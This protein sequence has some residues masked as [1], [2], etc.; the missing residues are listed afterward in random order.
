MFVRA[1]E[2][3]MRVVRESA[4]ELFLFVCCLTRTGCWG[5]RGGGECALLIFWISTEVEA[6]AEVQ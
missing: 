5:K 4:R 3:A 1:R 2:S 6:A